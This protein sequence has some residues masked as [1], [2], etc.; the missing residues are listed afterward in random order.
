VH[1]LDDIDG[2]EGAEAVQFS[3]LGIDYEI[4]LTKE[5]RAALQG[6]LQTFVHAARK[7]PS[8]PARFRWK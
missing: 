1:V 7:V 8:T 3:Y 2:S 6:A 5:N 4:Y